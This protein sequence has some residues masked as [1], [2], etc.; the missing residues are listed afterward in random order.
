MPNLQNQICICTGEK[1]SSNELVSLLKNVGA[2]AF[3]LPMIEI[4]FRDL[5]EKITSAINEINNYNWLLFTSKNGVNSFFKLLKDLSGNTNLPSS[6]K[7]ASI[8]KKTSTV[9]ESYNKKVDF[10]CSKNNAEDFVKEFTDFL[11]KE[12]TKVLFATGNL[13]QDSIYKACPNYIY[14]NKIVTYNTEL[15]KQFDEKITETIKQKTYNHIIFMSPSGVRNFVN[16]FG[17]NINPND[18]QAV[19]FGPSTTRQLQELGIEP[20]IIAKQHNNEGIVNALLEHYE[21]IAKLLF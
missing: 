11:P 6:L 21:N 12:P 16:L 2:T 17:N 13:T 9:I 18:L 3:S 15:P 7:I 14:I 4:H 8:G 19:S 20:K 1:E 5:S 10:T